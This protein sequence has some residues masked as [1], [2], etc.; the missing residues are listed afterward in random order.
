MSL[1]FI[2]NVTVLMELALEP[3]SPTAK[4]CCAVDL[5]PG[6]RRRSGNGDVLTDPFPPLVSLPFCL[7]LHPSSRSG[8]GFKRLWRVCKSR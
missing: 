6:Q 5:R 8:R 2:N 1:K 7:F 4:V 3:G